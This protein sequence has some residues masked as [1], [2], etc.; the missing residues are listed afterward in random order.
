MAIIATA[1]LPKP[2]DGKAMLAEM[3]KQLELYKPFMLHDFEQTTRSWTGEKPKF[4][5]VKAIRAS[6]MRL[7]VRVTGPEKGRRKWWYLEKGTRVRYA[8]MSKDFVAKTTTGQIYS[9]AGRGGAV[10]VSRAHPRPGIQARRWRET[11]KKRHEK[12]FPRWMEAV[13]PRAAA[14]S[15]H[16]LKR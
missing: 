14:A 4:V 15:G 6:E 10:H 7:S 2:I 12:T 5:I 8:V 9:V 11:T 1:I 13:M 16:A 3:E